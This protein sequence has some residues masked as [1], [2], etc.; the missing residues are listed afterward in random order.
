SRPR[1]PGRR[2]NR[3]GGAT[4]AIDENDAGHREVSADESGGRTGESLKKSTRR[5]PAEQAMS[6]R[7]RA[8]RR[9]Q[10]M[11]TIGSVLK[12]LVSFVVLVW[13]VLQTLAILGVNVA[14][15]IASAGI[16]GVALGFGAQALVRDF[17]SGIF[18]LFEDQ[19]GV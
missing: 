7:K 13:V 6:D 14:P 5:K 1:R 3:T 10:R 4:I 15:F 12:S 2:K 17:L 16:V 8:E 9:A 11:A 18:M 19:Y